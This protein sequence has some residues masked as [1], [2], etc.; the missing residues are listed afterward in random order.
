M[1][2]RYYLDGNL[3]TEPRGWDKFV[4]N[5]KRDK[6][7]NGISVAKELTLVFGQTE[8]D[9]FIN[10]ININGFCHESIIVIEYSEDNHNWFTFHTGVIYL[11][12][13]VFDEKRK[14]CTAKVQDNSFY[15]YLNN[16]INI[17]TYLHTDKSKNGETLVTPT[18]YSVAM[19]EC[20]T[21]IYY[22]DSPRGGYE[23]K[24][25][26]VYDVFRFL[27]EF[28]SDKKVQF[29]SNTFEVGGAYEEYFITTGYVLRFSIPD[30]YNGSTNPAGVTKQQFEESWEQLSFKKFFDEM[31]NRFNLKWW[32]EYSG[33]TPTLRIER[34]EDS[35]LDNLTSL[36]NHFV[37]EL[38]W[39]IDNEVLYANITLGNGAYTKQTPYL[40]FPDIPLIGFKD[41]EVMI[42]GQCN[43]NQTLDL[44]T[45]F[46]HDSNTIED[47]LNNG[48]ALAFTDE[49]DKSVF[50]VNA[51]FYITNPLPPFNDIYEAIPS[52]WLTGTLPSF[53][54]EQ[55]NNANIYYRFYNGFANSILSWLNIGGNYNF[56]AVYNYFGVAGTIPWAA[57][58]V[59]PVLTEPINFSDDSILGT[60]PSNTY[61]NGT[62]TPVTQPNSFFTSPQNGMFSFSVEFERVR[63][64]FPT[65][66]TAPYTIFLKVYDNTGTTLIT[67]QAIQYGAN[68]AQGDYYNVIHNFNPVYLNAGDRVQAAILIQNIAG[69]VPDPARL[70]WFRCTSVNGGTII[71]N[72]GLESPVIKYTYRVPMNYSE[73][74]LIEQNLTSYIYFRRYGDAGSRRGWIKSLKYN[75]KDCIADITLITSKEIL[76]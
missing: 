9:Y 58:P 10:L 29:A 73:L 23:Y 24:F 65:S 68:L 40:S 41:E 45:D 63:L 76:N 64:Q 46:I 22:P 71:T 62:T 59:I 56:T 75:H 12:D 34:E 54:N 66:N 30:N 4:T 67:S 48:W 11:T 42:A 70:A 28:M 69:V 5:I 35:R 6:S 57:S 36:S 39:E 15:A 32:I 31:N 33:A 8:Y 7:N 50:I 27:V 37:D 38:A 16:N 49:Y 17:G 26:K 74:K 60:D 20:S 25:Y 51:R 55:L 18:L 1:I 19:F 2:Y 43:L 44:H 3:I 72:D 21:G 53:Y 14:E 61:G 52:N 47:C 13:I